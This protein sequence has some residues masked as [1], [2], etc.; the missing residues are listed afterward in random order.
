MYPR[1]LPAAEA[2]VDNVPASVLRESSSL[3]LECMCRAYFEVS[4]S[5]AITSVEV[6]SNPLF[7]TAFFAM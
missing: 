6:R 2:A 4:A 7:N 5:L 1:V 3:F